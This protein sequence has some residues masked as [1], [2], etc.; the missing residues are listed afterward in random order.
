LKAEAELRRR[1]AEPKDLGSL[2]Y[3]EGAGVYRPRA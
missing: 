3:D 1:A 2:E